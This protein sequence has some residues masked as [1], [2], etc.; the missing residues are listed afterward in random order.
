MNQ[1]KHTPKSNQS[2]AVFFVSI[3]LSWNHKK[4]VLTMLPPGSL[5]PFQ[6]AYRV[7]GSRGFPCNRF[8]EPPGGYDSFSPRPKLQSKGC[9]AGFFWMFWSWGGLRMAKNILG[10]Q[11]IVQNS[12]LHMYIYWYIH[13]INAH[14]MHFGRSSRINSIFITLS[15]TNIPRNKA[16]SRDY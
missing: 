15:K 8:V 16:L 11:K 4:E 9:S 7:D 10:W 13:V 14:V 2:F 6:A 1:Q 3:P 5:R 12:V